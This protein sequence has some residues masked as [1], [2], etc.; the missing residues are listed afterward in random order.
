MSN[1]HRMEVG[2][3]RTYKGQRYV[4]TDEWAHEMMDG[5]WVAM[6]HLES[7]CADCGREFECSVVQSCARKRPLARRCER[8]HAPGRPVLRDRLHPN[9]RGAARVR[10]APS[11]AAPANAGRPLTVSA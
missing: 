1:H 3:T 11:F 9:A 4:A 8:C 7:Y 5:R 6:L 10:A 2:D